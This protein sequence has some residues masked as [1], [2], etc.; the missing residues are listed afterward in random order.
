VRLEEIELIHLARDG[1]H[2]AW[3]GLMR[4]HQEAVFRLAYLH[5]GDPDEAEDVAQETFIRAYKALRRFDTGRPMRPWLLQIAL[6]LVRN[7]QRS[8]GRYLAVLRRWSQTNPY[9]EQEIEDVAAENQDSSM[10][11]Q[12]VKRLPPRDQEVIYLRYFLELP[13]VQ[14]ADSLG[15]PPGTVKSRLHRALKRLE[16]IIEIDFPSLQKGRM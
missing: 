5:L 10:L 11:W 4:L 16:S 2:A 8:F 7:R 6:N 15:V 9:P 13:V 14:A 12:A 1:D 3:E